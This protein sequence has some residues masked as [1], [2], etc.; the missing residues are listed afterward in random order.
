L[1]AAAGLATVTS[2]AAQRRLRE[3]GDG[4]VALQADHPGPGG[5]RG[6]ERISAESERRVENGV[7]GAKTRVRDDRIDFTVLSADQAQRRHARAGT[8]G[9]AA[10]VEIGAARGEYEHGG[11]GRVGEDRGQRPVRARLGA[12]PE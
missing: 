9:A 4:A 3:R 7:A 12:Q 8:E 1:D 11:S 2:Q 6:D 10:L 5:V